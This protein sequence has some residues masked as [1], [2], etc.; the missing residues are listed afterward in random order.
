[1]QFLRNS[2]NGMEVNLIYLAGGFLASEAIRRLIAYWQKKRI[3]RAR[4]E[5][6]FFPDKEI[7]CKDFFDTIEGCR[8]NP[9][10]FGH[11]ITGF[12]YILF[13]K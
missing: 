9:C 4:C 7:A 11:E 12:R 13:F 5:V 3:E 2:G 1:M 6:I 8:N 10:S